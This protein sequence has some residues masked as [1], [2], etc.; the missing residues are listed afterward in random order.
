MTCYIGFMQMKQ[1]A[2]MMMAMMMTS[3]AES[4]CLHI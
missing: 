3:Q 1:A 2:G 4:Y